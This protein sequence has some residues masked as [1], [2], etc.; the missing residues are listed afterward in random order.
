MTQ[1][2]PET[3]PETHPETVT[4]LQREAGRSAEADSS[5]VAADGAHISIPASALPCPVC[6]GQRQEADGTWMIRQPLWEYVIENLRAYAAVD[7]DRVAV[8]RRLAN[9]IERE[10]KR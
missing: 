8:M 7:C 5:P 4:R 9:E 2:I 1:T 3:R 10:V 6:S